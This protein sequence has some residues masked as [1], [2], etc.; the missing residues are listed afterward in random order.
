[1]MNARKT[2]TQK[3]NRK[4]QNIFISDERNLSSRLIFTCYLGRISYSVNIG[5][6]LLNSFN[7][8]YFIQAFWC[9]EADRQDHLKPGA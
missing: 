4:Y 9:I 2:Q 6:T 8:D 5:K 1:M 7:G 3:K